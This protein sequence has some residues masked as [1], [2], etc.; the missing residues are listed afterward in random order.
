MVRDSTL[1]L[2]DAA[3]LSHSARAYVECLPRRRAADAQ[4]GHTT[5]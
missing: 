2:R 4:V 5:R 3:V 1:T